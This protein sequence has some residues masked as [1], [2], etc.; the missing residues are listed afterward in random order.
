MSFGK[1]GKKGEKINIIDAK[2][3]G[4]GFEHAKRIP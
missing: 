3:I 2:W 1:F 4:K